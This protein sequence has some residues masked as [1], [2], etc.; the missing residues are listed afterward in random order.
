MIK[1]TLKDTISPTLQALAAKLDAQGRKRL[2]A[3]MGGKVE[4]TLIA[5]FAARD[6]EPRQPGPF[7]RNRIKQNFWERIANV[8]AL[9][10]A[11]EKQATVVVA[12]RA[13]LLK[14]YGGTVRPLTAR[15][16]AIPMRQEADGLSPRD[17]PDDTFFKFVS[18]S[19]KAF[20]A[21]R[22][23]KALRLYYRLVASTRHRPDPRALPPIA[24][25]LAEMEAVAVKHLTPKA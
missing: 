17:W 3:E 4:D 5:H 10:S 12:D 1:L 11:T 22:E 15:A 24:L 18:K 21:K 20:L 19:G 9:D 6:Q 8:T 7:A 16:L 13:I 2:H 25:L 23:G 14:I